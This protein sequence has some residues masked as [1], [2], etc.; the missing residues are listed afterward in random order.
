[1]AP[2]TASQRA[3]LLGYLAGENPA[4]GDVSSD[5]CRQVSVLVLALDGLHLSDFEFSNKEWRERISPLCLLAN[6][7]EGNC[8][9]LDGM[10]NRS[11]S[12]DVTTTSTRPRTTRR[13]AK[14]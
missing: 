9:L 4:P 1:M 3:P 13:K 14:A 2:A 6:D 11:E 8:R 5:V 10:L 7:L 12:D